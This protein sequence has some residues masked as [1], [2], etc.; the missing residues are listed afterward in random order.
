VFRRM[1]AS[2]SPIEA[3]L[4]SNVAPSSRVMTALNG[5]SAPG[6]ETILPL[7][8]LMWPPSSFR[9]RASCSR[10]SIAAFVGI[11]KPRASWLPVILFVAAE[12]LHTPY[13]YH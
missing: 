1:N 9:C 12:L 3:K 11:S 5:D 2:A 13:G 6:V 8:Q 4:T 7:V 10:I